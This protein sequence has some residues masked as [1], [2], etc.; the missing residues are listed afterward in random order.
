MW[1]YTNRH[2]YIAV[3]AWILYLQ[4][5]FLYRWILY[6]R[7]ECQSSF[8]SLWL[9]LMEGFWMKPDNIN[10]DRQLQTSPSVYLR[11]WRCAPFM[12]GSVQETVRECL[13][14]VKQLK[15]VSYTLLLFIEKVK[16]ACLL[17]LGCSSDST[18]STTT[19]STGGGG[20]RMPDLLTGKVKR[21]WITWVKWNLF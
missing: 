8:S 11:V 4:H 5:L 21:K 19:S 2:V 10:Q 20:N 16:P 14:P 18:E 7:T 15:L 17:H 13:H 6:V 9:T 3:T 1:V 12:W